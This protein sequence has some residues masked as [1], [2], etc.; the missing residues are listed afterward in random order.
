MNSR[1]SIVILNW[2]GWR[3]TIECLESLYR[4]SYPNYDVILL[5]NGSNDGS[6]KEI[7]DYLDSGGT[8]VSKL[9]DYSAGNKPIMVLV[10]TAD[11]AEL[12]GG[13]E[14]EIADL[15]PDRRLVFIR[16]DQN[17]GFEQGNNIGV[18]YAIKALDPDYILLLNNDTVVDIDFLSELAKAD[19]GDKSI[20]SRLYTAVEQRYCGGHRFLKRACQGGRWR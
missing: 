6:L 5:D 7:R 18:R 11:E 9:V 19:D 16:N 1:V 2:N 17:C 12:G 10:Y 4:I 14:G 13:R 3:D 8:L 15:P 20:G